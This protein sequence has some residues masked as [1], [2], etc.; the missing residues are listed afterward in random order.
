M[1]V[2]VS[3]CLCVCVTCAYYI[4]FVQNYR[5]LPSQAFEYIQYN[6]GLESEHD[7]PYLAHDE[8]CKF[9]PSKV[10]AT[11]SAVH[12]ISQVKPHSQSPFP[13]PRGIR[14]LEWYLDQTL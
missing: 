13:S 7:Y 11:V 1:R 12:N 3:V 8:K 5:G 2:C 6:G 14:A 10:V 9:D 4:C